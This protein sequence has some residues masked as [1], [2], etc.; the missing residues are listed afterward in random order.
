MQYHEFPVPEPLKGY[1]QTMWA[2]ESESD[3]EQYPRSLIMP[4]GIVEAIFH[5]KEPFHYYQENKKYKQDALIAVSM[6]KKY[7]EIESDGATGFIAVR[8]F[9]WGA[10]HFFDTPISSFVD[11][12]INAE[13]LWPG[14][15]E[16]LISSLRDAAT[17][18]SRVE[19]IIVFL[20]EKLRLHQKEEAG[21][22]NVIRLIREY[23]G[24]LSIEQVAE[25][26]GINLKQLERKFSSLLGTTPKVFSRV[27]RFLDI[28]HHLHQH[29]GKSLTA[30][31]YECGYFDQSH[32]INDFKSF[33]GFTP[34]EFFEKE[35][36]WFTES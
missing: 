2:M 22:D 16:R 18:E 28:C 29:K 27:C 4:D 7:M 31:A 15:P 36:I 32:F 25:R 3:T 9:P 33:S 30:L 11:Q 21:T 20:L 35:H 23:K 8:F 19:I 26:T 17:L 12:T 10:Y 14:D 13:Q 34:K 24:T 6:M 5:Y 1:V